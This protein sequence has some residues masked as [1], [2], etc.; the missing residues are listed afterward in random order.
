VKKD[1]WIKILFDYRPN[2][3]VQKDFLGDRLLQYLEFGGTAKLLVILFVKHVLIIIRTIEYV[4][5]LSTM[6]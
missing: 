5:I 1:Q 4:R 6:K 3:F 2:M